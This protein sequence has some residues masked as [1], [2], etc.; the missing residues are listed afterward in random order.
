MTNK[1]FQSV[2]DLDQA[3]DPD[4][5]NIPIMNANQ[6]QENE[7]FVQNNDNEEEKE[8]LEEAKVTISPNKE[9]AIVLKLPPLSSSNELFIQTPKEV[10][11]ATLPS[12]KD[13]ILNFAS[14]Q[15]Q[16]KA[17]SKD[18]FEWNNFL[19]RRACFRG[20]SEYFKK[21][22]SKINISWQRKRVNKKKKTPMHDLIKVFAT[23][24]FGSMVDTLDQDQWRDFRNTLYSVLF[25][26]RYKKT[27]DFLE[28]VDFSVIRGVLYSYTTELRVELMSNPFF[29]IMMLNFLEN[30]K[31]AFLKDKLKGK[32]VLYSEEVKSELDSLEE[33]ARGHLSNYKFVE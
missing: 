25:S 11:E 5:P 23:N 12:S 18:S 33:E 28:G 17:K 10:K 29:S 6:N 30:G 7:R 26:H 14:Q 2:P 20:L 32:P 27:D 16:T 15:E 8:N 22:F 13:S 4:L 19:V 24:E 1:D 3:V 9:D 31:E 21:K